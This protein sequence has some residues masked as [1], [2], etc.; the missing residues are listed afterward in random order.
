MVTSL[1][2]LVL[3]HIPIFLLCSRCWNVANNALDTPKIVTFQLLS[4][5]WL[6][7]V[8]LTYVTFQ[9]GDRV[10]RFFSRAFLRAVFTIFCPLAFSQLFFK[11]GGAA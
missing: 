5:F 1:Q 7:I 4:H 11:R 3:G 2:W 8:S 6:A 10:S 9:I